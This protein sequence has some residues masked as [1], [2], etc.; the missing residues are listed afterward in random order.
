MAKRII[1]AD[2]DKEVREIITFVLTHNGFEVLAVNNGQQLHD[3][4]AQQLPDILIL[5]VMMPG[6]DGYHLCHALRSNPRTQ[7]IPIIIMTA[8]TEEIYERISIDLGVAE[9]IT[10]PFH[11]LALVERVKALLPKT[12][13]N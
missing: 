7:Y 12:A 11:P 10:K 13:Q 1:V 5:D 8:H 9:H 6:E 4:L 3:V 2:D